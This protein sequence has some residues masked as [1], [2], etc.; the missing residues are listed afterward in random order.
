MKLRVALLAT[1]AITLLA[2]CDDG[3]P[4][5]EERAA[6]QQEFRTANTLIKPVDKIIDF[7][8]APSLA[9]VPDAERPAA[10]PDRNA[11]F[12]DLH[13]HTTYSF[14]ASAFGTTATPADAYRYAKG[15]AIKHPSGLELQ[16]SQPLDF[17]AVTDHAIFLGMINEAADTSTAFSKHKLAQDYHNINDEVDGGLLDLNARSKV[18]FNFVSDVVMAL[19]RGEITEDET[20]AISSNTWQTTVQAA[21]DA[22]VPG[23][24]TTFAGYEFSSST[25]DRGN[26]HR[27]V[28]F[29]GTDRLP[30]KP[31]SRFNSMNP[32]GLWG[33]M[34]GLRAQDIESL[35]IPHNSNGS[36]GAM[37]ELVNWADQ[38][39]DV[40]YAEQR[41]RNEPLVEITQVKGT[42][43]THPLLSETDEWAD[44]EIVD[45]RVGT[46]LPSTPPGGYVRDAYLRGLALAENGQGNPYKFGVIGS[47]DTHVGGGSFDEEN[48]FGKVGVMDVTAETRGSVPASWAYGT[49]MKIAVPEMAP[50]IEGETYLAFN[51]YERWS[52][53]GLTGVWAEEN[54]RESIY[55][56][57][58]RQE[59][60]A[61][62]GPRMRVRFF[63]GFGLDDLSLDS[64][65]LVRDAYETANAMGSTLQAKGDDQPSFLVWA[66]ADVN[67]S[68]L[69]RVQIIKGWVEN[70]EHKERVYDVA[71]SDGFAVDPATNRCPDNGARV[72][73]AD[74]S[75]TAGV[76]AGELKTFWRDPDF[77]AGEEA[78]YYVRVLQNPTCRWST[79]DAIRN[80]TKP[81]P[82]L[83]P[84]IQERA[85]SSPIWYSKSA[86]K[87]VKK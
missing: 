40:A 52:A 67:T 50:E 44:F 51:T 25:P 71:C 36:N 13:V 85:W 86:A 53:S 58:R 15:E 21:N 39:I 69:Q 9:D 74:C 17:Y 38:P 2:A 70:G 24:F 65:T 10:N 80:G 30:S 57:L 37:F 77:R 79:W 56:A 11:Y 28:I 61:T 72:N 48:H 42:S 18:F 31:F 33:W 14:D 49:M 87:M 6:A 22:Y 19:K 20:N 84:T 60:F 8:S 23:K 66:M 29:E 16:L 73:L 76:G 55:A 7:P 32:E 83:P 41:L 78:F 1:T 75:T 54:T 5:D 59:T 68:P 47:S 63:A 12:G 34:D 3:S 62:S 46:M 26:L 45:V 64:N 82:D 81:R 43:D 35:A 27:N 4:T